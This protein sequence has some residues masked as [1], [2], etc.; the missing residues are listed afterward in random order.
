M[1]TL[2]IGDHLSKLDNYHKIC[3]DKNLKPG[4]TMFQI[5]QMQPDL[6][7]MVS[8]IEIGYDNTLLLIPKFDEIIFLTDHKNYTVRL[9]QHEIET[10]IKN[11][12]NISDNTFVDINKDKLNFFGCSHTYGIGHLSE[13]TTYPYLLSD[14]LSVEYNNFSRPGNSNYGIED[15]LTT[16]SLKDSN[17]IIQFT[18]IYRIRYMNKSRIEDCSIHTSDVSNYIIHCEENLF[19]DF[20]NIVNRLVARLRDGDN[21]FILTHACHFDNMYELKVTEFLHGFKEFDSS[22]GCIVD[23]GSDGL[24][25]GTESH[26]RW[27]T[28][29][30]KK[31]IDLYGTTY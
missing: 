12:T 1:A 7:Y 26:R 17:L 8:P 16:F 4:G 22:I 23:T 14:L 21:K 2:F 29:L 3:A 25:Y 11:R 5:D 6:S 9:L 30:H 18:D 19:F 13:N 28:K 15:L 31:W 10:S 20:K 27:A 24:H